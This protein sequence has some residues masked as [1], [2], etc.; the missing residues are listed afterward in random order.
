M[1]KRKRERESGDPFC[2]SSFLFA[3][4]NVS[5]TQ[6]F[7]QMNFLQIFIHSQWMIRAE[8][9]E[10]PVASRDTV[11]AHEVIDARERGERARIKRSEGH[12]ALG[13]D[14]SKFQQQRWKPQKQ[15]QWP[16]R[17]SQGLCRVRGIH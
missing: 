1:R 4:K 11:C 14:D 7:K 13:P 2:P 8:C 17:E 10:Q 16:G 6:L 5:P 9:R 3:E 15:Q 12:T